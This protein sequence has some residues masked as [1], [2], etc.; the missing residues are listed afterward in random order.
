MIDFANYTGMSGMLNLSLL[1]ASSK[2]SETHQLV[3][4]FR[5]LQIQWPVSPFRFFFKL[6][7]N[8]WRDGFGLM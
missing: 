5:K 8:K 6:A 7:F 4:R 3:K 2:L 1:G